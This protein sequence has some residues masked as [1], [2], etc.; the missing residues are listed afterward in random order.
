MGRDRAKSVIIDFNHFREDLGDPKRLKSICIAIITMENGAPHPHWD[1]IALLH[2]ATRH[3]K[4]EV[5][6]LETIKEEPVPEAKHIAITP[7]KV[8]VLDSFD[9]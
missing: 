1:S 7:K 3:D 8:P 2:A 9:D 4:K 5:K 6:R